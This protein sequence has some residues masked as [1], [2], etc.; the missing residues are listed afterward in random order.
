M[1]RD[2]M[3][4][5]PDGVEACNINGGWYLKQPLPIYFVFEGLAKLEIPRFVMVVKKLD[6]FQCNSLKEIVFSE[7]GSLNTI[8]GFNQCQGIHGIEVP[9]TVKVIA[10][11]DGCSSLEDIL[12]APHTGLTQITSF[13]HLDSL[14]Q[15]E[16]PGSV[17]ATA[18]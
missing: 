9:N 11:F 6:F 1:P 12:F 16:I 4:W 7:N 5:T 13:C 17:E 14:A 2:N 10:G 15:I 3:L 18:D 8:D